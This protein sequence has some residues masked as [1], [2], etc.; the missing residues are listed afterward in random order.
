[1]S[2]RLVNVTLDNLDDLPLRCRRCV[3][4]ELDPVSRA[5]AEEAGDPG[6][7][8]EAWISSTL[9]EWGSCGKIVYAD[10]V[11]AGYVL[12][13]PPLYVPRSVAFPTSPVSADAV[14]L[15][16]AN[17]ISEFT[18]GGLGRMLVQGAAKD[19]TRRGVKA[20]EAFGDVRWEAPACVL[21]ADYLLAVGFKTIRPHH[22]FPR[23]RLELRTALSWREDV[24]VALERLLGSMTPER[25]LRP[26]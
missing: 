14:L 22:R 3:F 17:V 26:A 23:L 12:Y 20:I 8:K 4:W 21:P 15:M 16:A 13:A 18:G 11:S 6:L 19:L 1:V 2:R 25:A 5:R 10:G 9:L 24:E 7:E